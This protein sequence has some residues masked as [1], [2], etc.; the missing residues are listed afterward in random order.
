MSTEHGA[1]STH[2][3]DL[4][5]EHIRYITMAEARPGMVLAHDVNVVENG[6]LRLTMARGTVL[7]PDTIHQL[8]M[9]HGEFL[10][11]KLN[12]KRS[13]AECDADAAAARARV[14]QIFAGADFSNPAINNLMQA[15]LDYRLIQGGTP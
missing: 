8:T 7:C 15:V 9:H 2:P 10:A 14:M 11:I 4:P 1:G 13:K 6:M 5:P 3:D 12:D